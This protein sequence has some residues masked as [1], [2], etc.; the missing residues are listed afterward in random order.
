MGHVRLGVLPRTKAWKEVVGLIAAGANVSQIANA[1]I[2]AAEKAFSFVMNDVGYTEAVWLMTQMAIA[3]K[4]PDI[5]QHLAA[6]GIHLPTDPSLVDVTT[7][8]T[9]ALD[10]RVEGTG[11]RSDLGMLANRAIV[12]AVNDVLAPKLHS[13]F[14]SDPDTM[15]AALAD[16][17]KPR[18]FGEFSRHFFARLANEGLQ[19]FLSKVINTQLGE[20]MRF[21]TM[22]QA[23]EF[24]LALQ[25]H[26]REASLIVEQFS[27]EW[28]SKHRYH[29]GGDISRKSSDG[30]AG[31]ALKKMRD[32][33]KVGAS[34]GDAR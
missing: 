8:I 10:R 26:T 21:A 3:A 31:Y 29:E 5:H 22:N 32:E 17:G 7:A 18:E 12:G 15:R 27:S 33:L 28:F 2:T 14:S 9:E 16:L 23:A 13:L 1:T 20:G 6:A 30:F 11:K 4:K 25:T 19:Y 24:N 34:S